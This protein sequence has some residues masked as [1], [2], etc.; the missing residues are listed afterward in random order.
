MRYSLLLTG[1]EGLPRYLDAFELAEQA[2]R[3]LCRYGML[4]SLYN[5]F[6]HALSNSENHAWSSQSNSDRAALLLLK[7]DSDW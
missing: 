4:Y 5:V 7:I 2:L 1:R 3:S 6:L